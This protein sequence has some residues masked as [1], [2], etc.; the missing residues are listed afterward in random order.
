MSKDRAAQ[1]FGE[2]AP[3]AVTEL[4]R[5]W[6]GGSARAGDELGRVVYDELRRQARHQ[7]RHERGGRQLLQ[8]TAL[9][10]EAYLRLIEL[11]VEWRDRGHFFT[12]A[13]RQ[14][15]RVLVDSARARRSQ[16]RGEPL[17]VRLDPEQLA[18]LGVPS[19]GLEIL[20]LDRA[21]ERLA[22]QDARKARVVELR[23][24]A[25]LSI[26]ETGECLEISAATVE[27]DLQMGKAF[28]RR[29]LGEDR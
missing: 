1:H 16:K 8:T 9:V 14:M 26:A 22:A 13:A 15:R 24:F 28:L 7:M 10:H 17:G 29:E 6:R 19:Q 21:L 27:R 20:A 11:R 3:G 23:L 12:V 4:L 25:G 18:R 2:R 5:R